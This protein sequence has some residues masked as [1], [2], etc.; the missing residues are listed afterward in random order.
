VKIAIAAHGSDLSAEVGHRLGASQYLI[1]VDVDSGGF[2]AVTNPGASGQRGAGMQATVL[3]ISRDVKS[4][5]TRYCSPAV[6]D[7][8]KANGIEVLTGVSGTLGRFVS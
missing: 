7:Q 8:L 4:V 3:A 2:E 5:L 1:I 6:Q